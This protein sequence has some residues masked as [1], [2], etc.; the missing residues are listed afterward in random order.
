MLKDIKKRVERLESQQPHAEQ[1]IRER[2]DR[3]INILDT[4]D[5]STEEGRMLKAV[6]EK[7]GPA[8]AEIEDV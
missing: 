4:E 2:I 8:L 6:I 7:Y 5:F 3:Y 1:N